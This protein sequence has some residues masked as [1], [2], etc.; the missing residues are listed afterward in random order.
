MKRRHR[1]RKGEK[2]DKERRKDQNKGEG[3]GRK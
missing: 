1:G 3:G 2:E